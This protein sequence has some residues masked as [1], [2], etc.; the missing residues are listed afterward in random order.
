VRSD[1]GLVA[2][3]RLGFDVGGGVRFRMALELYQ[4][5]GRHNSRTTETRTERFGTLGMA[6]AV[7]YQF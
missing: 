2:G 5:Y 4:H 1:T 3:P 7:G 6:I